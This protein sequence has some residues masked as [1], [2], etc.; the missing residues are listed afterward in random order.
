MSMSRLVSALMGPIACSVSQS[1]FRSGLPRPRRLIGEGAHYYP[2]ILPSG[3]RLPRG[4]M[5]SASSHFESHSVKILARRSRV[6][7]RPSEDSRST[8]ILSWSGGTA[9]TDFRATEALAAMRSC[10]NIDSTMTT[11]RL[12]EVRKNYYIPSKYE[13]H[14]PLPGERPYDA[15]P[16]SFSMSTDTLEVGLSFLTEWTSR[17]V[18]NS[19]P[20]LSAN[21]IELVEI[22]QGILS[23]SMNMNEAWLAEGGLSPAS[24]GPVEV[25]EAPE[26]GYT[27]WDLCEVEDRVGAERYFASIMTRLKTIEVEDPLALRWS[28]ISG[29]T[30]VWTEGPLV[31]KYLWGGSTPRS[32]KASVRVLFRGAYEQGWQLG[33]NQELDVTTEHRAKELE[34][35]VKRLRAELDLDGARDDRTRL[36]GDVLSLTEATTLLEAELKAKWSKAMDAYKASRGFESCLEKM[37]RVSYEFG[38]RVALER[39]RGKHPEIE[40]E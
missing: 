1:R 26:R 32:S 25:K 28:A 5:S 6:L 20:V 33:P 34:E 8:I 15:F 23:T 13:L 11:H 30:Q 36:E 37:G 31:T 14:V 4:Q 2:I 18:N 19:I 22:L 9:P 3:R 40:I 7:G 10:F 38:Y 35:D 27:I 17:T 21:E 29:S 24:W 39:L 12:V 16:S